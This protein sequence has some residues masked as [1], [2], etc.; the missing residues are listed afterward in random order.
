MHPLDNKPHISD[1]ARVHRDQYLFSRL[2]I[3]AMSFRH[4][5]VNDIYLWYRLR[6]EGRNKAGWFDINKLTKNERYKV[7][8]KLRKKGWIHPTQNRTVR[9]KKLAGKMCTLSASVKIPV[10]VLET[11]E[12]FKAFIYDAVVKWQLEG[13]HKYTNH[14][15]TTKN[16]GKKRIDSS[17]NTIYRK[18]KLNYRQAFS[19]KDEGFRRKYFRV[20]K[21]SEGGLDGSKEAT[22]Q[23]EGRLSR[24]ITG[25]FLDISESTVSRYR[26][27]AV[28]NTYTL[29]RRIYTHP[30]SIHP[31]LKYYYDK[32]ANRYFTIS[33]IVKTDVELF[34]DKFARSKNRVEWVISRRGIIK[35]SNNN[36]YDFNT[37]SYNSNKNV[38]DELNQL[39]N[40]ELELDYTST[41][42]NSL[43]N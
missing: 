28:A 7:L 26:K 12:K 1:I 14:F 13:L 9:Y 37:H 34:T 25:A 20:R 36:S 5:T 2:E 33:T 22:P 8:P 19:P 41:S 35:D 30:S 43:F 16:I 24:S 39:T 31:M 10:H 17:D 11:K 40:E 18:S 15:W 27:M 32:K 38:I 21:F 23:Y 29:D 4:K 42:N 6:H 3:L